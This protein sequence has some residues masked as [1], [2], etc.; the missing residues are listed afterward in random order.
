MKITQKRRKSDQIGQTFDHSK[1]GLIFPGS[2]YNCSRSC[3][4]L[5]IFYNY[6][7]FVVNSVYGVEGVEPPPLVELLTPDLLTV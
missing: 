1:T 5:S 2:Y 6:H 3:R 7:Y 4:K